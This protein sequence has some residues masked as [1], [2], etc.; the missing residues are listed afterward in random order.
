VIDVT[1]FTDPGCP[2]AYSASPA[3]TTLRWRYGDQLRWTLVMIGLTEEAAQY[4]ARGYTPTRSALGLERFRRFSMPFQITPKQRLSATSPGCRAIVATRLV[5]PE[6]EDATLRALQFAQFTTTGT[7]DDPD[8]LRSALATVEGLDADAVVGRIEDPE[9]VEAYEADRAAARTA[10]GSPTEF[11]G[12]AAN[13]DG[14][15][16]Y[17]A[18][19]L[20]FE[21][22]DGRRLETG[23]FQPLEAYDVVIANLDPT[24]VRRPPADEALD[25][26]SAFPYP[27]TTAEVAAVM[28]EHLAVPDLAAAEA[29]LITA[30]GD[31][32]VRRRPVGDGSLWSLSGNS[33]TST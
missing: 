31:G 20:V 18:P 24:L 3:H 5:A 8:M 11:Q 33:G 26:L 30:A 7:L 15:V 16:R 25:V 17:T 22:D 2:W 9:V 23:G 29:A 1:H 32:L 12:R 27:L 19:S 28:A 13:T 4:A 10:A 6:L 21:T 14:A